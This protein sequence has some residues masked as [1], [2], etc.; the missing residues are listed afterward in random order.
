MKTRATCLLSC[1][2]EDIFVVLLIVVVG[3]DVSVG[4]VVVVR[5]NSHSPPSMRTPCAMVLRTPLEL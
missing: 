5:A 3:V 2:R 1:A 4:V